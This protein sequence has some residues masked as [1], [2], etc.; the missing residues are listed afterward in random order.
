ME[1]VPSSDEQAT[2]APGSEAGADGAAKGK[3]QAKKKKYTSPL[4]NPT[5]ELPLLG[6]G[7]LAR[8]LLYSRL[9]LGL[10]L[11]LFTLGVVQGV[12]HSQRAGSL[13]STSSDATELTRRLGM[14]SSLALTGEASALQDAVNSAQSLA[15]QISTMGGSR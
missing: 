9:L 10:G 2:K 11:L 14:V 3:D 5:I 12:W 6:K 15:D 8:H 7:R 1:A 13:Y 4:G